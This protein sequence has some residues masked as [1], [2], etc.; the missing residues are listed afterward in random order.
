MTPL[1]ERQSEIMARARTE[2]RILI[3]DLAAVLAVTTQTIRRDVNGLCEAGLLARVHG[4]AKLA[5]GTVNLDYAER[6]GLALDGKRAI[7]AAAAAMIPDDCSVTINIGTTTEQVAQALRPRRNLVVLTN[8]MN[9][10]NILSGAAGKEIILAGGAVRPGDGAIVGADA[11]EFIGKF[12]TDYAII[13]SSALDAD[14][15]ILDFDA[16][17]VAVARA[18]IAN[19]RHTIL[20]CDS[21]KFERSAS[22]RV[23]ALDDIDAFVTDAPPPPSFAAACAR[24]GV[25]VTIADAQEE[26]LDD[27]NA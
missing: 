26:H 23:C 24:A 7:G 14:G 13:G 4:G 8:N 9:V 1:N 20:V 25:A 19:T 6:R 27:F 3:D 2:G 16:R 18:I 17:E 11:V 21:Q 22:V 12:K 5:T 15:S 10:A